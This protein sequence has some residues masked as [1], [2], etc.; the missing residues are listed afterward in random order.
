MVV[1]NVPCGTAVR[2]PAFYIVGEFIGLNR[3]QARAD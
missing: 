3:L 2:W 1:S